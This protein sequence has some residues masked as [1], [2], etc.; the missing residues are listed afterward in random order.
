MYRE[1]EYYYRVLGL[2]PGA[3]PAAI[4]SSYRQLVKLYHP[5]RDKS[6]DSEIM[7]REVRE[8]YEKLV[9]SELKRKIKDEPTVVYDYS[10][11]T[12]QSNNNSYGKTR[13]SSADGRDASKQAK[14]KSK[15]WENW[16]RHKDKA[17]QDIESDSAFYE[18]KIIYSI[19]CGYF[20]EVF[21]VFVYVAPLLL[22]IYLLDHPDMF[23]ALFILIIIIFASIFIHD[24]RKK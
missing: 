10:K 16:T 13:Q 17:S 11:K 18:F 3:S 4:K 1:N 24:M 15:V 21:K 19:I 6:P 5:D 9:N 23:F 14:W 12:E 7:Y 8:A 20:K 2:H 22:L